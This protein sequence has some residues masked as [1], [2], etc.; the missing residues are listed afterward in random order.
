[1]TAPA[2]MAI[3]VPTPPLATQQSFDR[4][5][6]EIAALKAKHSAIREA[7]AALLPATLE[8]VFAGAS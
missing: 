6:A 5:Q 8:R 3:E 4:L 7:N 1:M 2:L